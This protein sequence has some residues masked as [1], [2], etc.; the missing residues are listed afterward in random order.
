MFDL[1]DRESYEGIDVWRNNFLE[2]IHANNFVNGRSISGEE[3]SE[4]A[5]PIMLVGNKADLGKNKGRQVEERQVIA[6]WI[7]SGEALEYLETSAVTLHNID[8]L[9][10]KIAD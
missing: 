2:S 4:V 3:D 7:E 10:E 8:L 1:T 6:D 9:F 5:A